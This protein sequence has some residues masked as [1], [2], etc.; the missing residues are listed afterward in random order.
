MSLGAKKI[1]K[2]STENKSEQNL[3]LI[4]TKETSKL[5]FFSGFVHFK[6]AGKRRYVVEEA[7]EAEEEE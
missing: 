4:S 7:E 5:V 1:R 2:E 3:F 6:K